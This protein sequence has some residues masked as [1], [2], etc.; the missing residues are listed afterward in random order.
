[1]YTRPHFVSCTLYDMNEAAQ[2]VN[3]NRDISLSLKSVFLTIAALN[4]NAQLVADSVSG[5]EDRRNNCP[6]TIHAIDRV[7]LE[8]DR[9]STEA[10]VIAR[11][12]RDFDDCMVASSLKHIDEI[13]GENRALTSEIS[14]SVLSSHGDHASI[15]ASM[16]DSTNLDSTTVE[17][18][19]SLLPSSTPDAA[20]S[21][22]FDS[23]EM[24]NS[25][26]GAELTGEEHDEQ[27]LDFAKAMEVRE[28]KTRS[29]LNPN[30]SA[31]FTTFRE[32][33]PQL[34]VLVEEM[35][36]DDYARV[37]YEAYQSETDPARREAL[38]NE[39]TTYLKF[40]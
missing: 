34:V 9:A 5:G 36:F 21:N 14:D 1:M 39:L 23:T 8:R 38:A 35:P 26:V 13:S 25:M 15:T 32:G 24:V 29:R 27:R 3:A 33:K 7:E 17:K 40:E 4:A 12:L 30:E 19:G 37:L 31:T 10:R 11:L 28:Q 18:S 16:I 20:S 2:L 22:S 6:A